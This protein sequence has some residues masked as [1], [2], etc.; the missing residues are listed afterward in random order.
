MCRIYENALIP[1]KS[2]FQNILFM[3]IETYSTMFLELEI[4]LKALDPVM[5]VLYEL[6]A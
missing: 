2:E 4:F 6:K 3:R 1:E 5:S